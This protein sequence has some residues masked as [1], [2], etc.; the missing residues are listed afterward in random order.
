MSKSKRLTPAV[1]YLRYSSDQQAGSDKQQDGEIRKLAEREGCKIIATFSDE[2]ISGDTGREDRPGLSDLLDAAEAGQFDVLLAWDTSRIGRQDSIDAGPL[3]KVL[4]DKGILIHTC[5]DGSFNLRDSNNRLQY[6]FYSEGNNVE[7]RRRAYNAVRGQIANAKRGN[8]N[9]AKA[10]FGMDRAQFNQNGTL[11]R[12]LRL[13][14]Q[15]DCADHS[16]R[17]IPCEDEDKIAAVEYAFR[18]FTSVDVSYRGLAHE[19]NDRGFPS[20]EG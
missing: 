9:G 18:R 14:Q 8:R 20:A 4:K 6:A 10:N 16:V 12:R 2:A 5:R 17:L 3:L 7:N 1:A 15:K 19:M 11:V 13:G